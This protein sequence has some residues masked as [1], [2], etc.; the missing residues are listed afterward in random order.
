M[1]LFVLG[2][3]A[4]GVAAQILL[5]AAIDS[6][7]VGASSSAPFVRKTLTLIL[8][9]QFLVAMLFVGLAGVLW[10]ILLAQGTQISSAFPLLSFSSVFV[11]FIAHFRLGEPLTIPKVIGTLLIVL[12]AILL[13][14]EWGRVS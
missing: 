7:Q 6:A 1:M 2:T 4:S 3:C 5:K 8:S 10:V 12:G 14:C 11:V 9:S 13:T